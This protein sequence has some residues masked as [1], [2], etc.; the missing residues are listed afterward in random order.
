MRGVIGSVSIPLVGSLGLA[1]KAEA[2]PEQE[3]NGVANDDL[4]HAAKPVKL[5]SPHIGQDVNVLCV[6]KLVAGLR[7]L[8]EVKDIDYIHVEDPLTVIMRVAFADPSELGP[9]VDLDD[10]GYALVKCVDCSHQGAGW[11]SC[12]KR[13][14]ADRDGYVCDLSDEVPTDIYNQGRL[15]NGPGREYYYDSLKARALAA[16][17]PRNG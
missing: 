10:Q 9:Q 13:A 4:R 5:Y 6:E 8:Y 7:N 16:R 11:L 12:F 17:G 15:M 3:L 2:A 1:A 14:G